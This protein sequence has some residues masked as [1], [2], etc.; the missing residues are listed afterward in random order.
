MCP[1]MPS[2]S[3][4]DMGVGVAA[5]VSSRGGQALHTP[6]PVSVSV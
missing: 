4:F 6:P 3:P 5:A 1:A 2:T